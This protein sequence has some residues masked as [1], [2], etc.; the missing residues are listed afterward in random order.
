[1]STTNH[2]RHH[3][4]IRGTLAQGA[5]EAPDASAIAD[6]TLNTWRRMAD[7][8]VPVIG[9]RGVDALFSRSLHV[10]S[11]TFPWLAMAGND[12]SN[13]ALMTDLKARLADQETAAAAE[14]SHALLVNLTELL[15][16]LIGA[17]LTERLLTP[18]WLQRYI[19]I[20]SRLKRV[21]AV[22]KVRGSAHS[23]ELRQFEITAEGIIIGDTVLDYEGL[24]GGQPMRT[25]AA[26][27]TIA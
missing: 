9:A 10:T 3:A 19:E 17:S 16:T 27:G 24:L 11:K 26:S 2:D 13:A 22:V 21:M 12:G 20:E 5:G 23:N 14:A 6:A 4:A 1:M 7:R 8:L 15:T 25:P 18:V